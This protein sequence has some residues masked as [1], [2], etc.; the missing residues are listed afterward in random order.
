M[1]LP[2]SFVLHQ[3]SSCQTSSLTVVNDSEYRESRVGV[4]SCLNM[5]AVFHAVVLVFVALNMMATC[6]DVTVS[7]TVKFCCCMVQP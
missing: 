4:A 2:C 5:M 1:C 3:N 6:T 7:A